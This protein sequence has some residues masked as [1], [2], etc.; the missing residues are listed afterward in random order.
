MFSAMSSLSLRVRVRSVLPLL[1]VVW[2]LGCATGD[3]VA[4]ASGYQGVVELDQRVLSFPVSE[5]VTQVRVRRGQRVR[6]G[7]LLVTLDD[8]L[9]AAQL[10]IRKAELHNTQARLSLTTAGARATEIRAMAR[11]LDAL[12]AREALLQRSAEREAPLQRTGAIATARHD[13][14]LSELQGVREQRRAAEQRLRQLRQGAREQDVEIAQAQV[15]GAEA[16]LAA[17]E[18]RLSLY[19]LR[20]PAKST[21]VDVHLE[22]GE[23]ASAGAPVV[24]VADIDHPY[25]DVFVPQAE[26]SALQVGAAMAVEVDGFEEP[27]A[28]KIEH[29]FPELEYTPHFLFSEEERPELVLRVRVQIADPSHRLHAG[30]PVRVTRAANPSGAG[31]AR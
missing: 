31:D 8:T 16:A 2:S 9:Q 28:G 20:S 10:Q 1:W 21:V 17:E 25:A 29:V 6:R 30:V 15:E 4:G 24:T 27:L 26:V 18:L 14:T 23:M 13:R 19:E 3:E 7:D 11:D 12:K 22:N 5:R